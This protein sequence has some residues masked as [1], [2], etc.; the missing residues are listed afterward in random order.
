MSASRGRPPPNRLLAQLSKRES[1]AVLDECEA[2][3]LKYGEI[4][5]EPDTRI[6]EVY[7]PTGSFISLMIPVDG[8]ANL[9]VGLIGN[10]GMLGAS[11][12]LGVN[13]SA[14]RARVQGSGP[15][16]RMTTATFLRTLASSPALRH[17]LHRYLQVRMSQTEQAAACT[18]FHVVEQRLARWLLMTQDRAHGNAFHATHEILAYMLGVRRVGVTKAAHALQ[19]RRLIRYHRGEVTILDRAGIEAASCACYQVDR[20]TYDALLAPSR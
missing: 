13:V 2:V 1:Q 18:R 6:R 5:Y 9:E 15:A 20:D 3:D 11:L 7:F 19:M 17:A 8:T 4:L 16:W 10:E 12:V 14:L